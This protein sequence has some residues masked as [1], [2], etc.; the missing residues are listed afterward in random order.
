MTIATL[1]YALVFGSLVAVA[2]AALDACLR[3]GKRATRGVWLAA[4]GL[5]L[6]GTMLARERAPVP[7]GPAAGGVAAS[8]AVPNTSSL[9][10]RI[11]QALVTV[12]AVA[13]HLADRALA[14][15]PAAHIPSLDRLLTVGWIAVSL[16]VL[17]LLIAV[18]VHFRR[19]RRAWPVAT[20]DGTEVRLA[21]RTG[22]AVIGLIDPEIVVPAW[23]MTR[24][25]VEQRLVLDHERE[26]LRARDPLLL[27]AAYVTAALMPWH[28]A[29]WWMLARLRLAVEL[30]CDA[31]VLRRGVTAGSYGALLIDL[32]GRGTASAGVPALGLTLTNLE[33]R[34][35]AMTPHRRSHWFVRGSL[36]AGAALVAFAIACNAPV[37]TSPHHDDVRAQVGDATR[38]VRIPDDTAL[39]RID[40]LLP[41]VQAD[42]VRMS[43]GIRYKLTLDPVAGQVGKRVAYW[44][45]TDVAKPRAAV[46]H[47]GASM[48]GVIDRSQALR[49]KIL[50][51]SA[52]SAMIHAKRSMGVSGHVMVDDRPTTTLYLT[53]IVPDSNEIV[54]VNKHAHSTAL[55]KVTPDH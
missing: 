6:A 16:A 4:L 21:P 55:S 35:I 24:A 10:D 7:T 34:L 36:L 46:G 1:A 40:R 50:V 26:H 48:A 27:S 25:S 23:L 28:P 47:V 11:V 14:R 22:P 12:R 44:L 5:T 15:I 31:R 42:S 54:G 30:D 3:L 29:V 8:A 9:V 51:D 13:L 52:Q 41:K 37:P 2:A 19:A 39:V 20:V 49:V 43:D 17:A 45:T 53:Q 18:H 33:R 32:A 38:A